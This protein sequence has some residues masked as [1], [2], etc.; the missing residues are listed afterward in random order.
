MEDV[1]KFYGYLVYYMVIWSIIWLFGLLYGYLVNFVPIW[2]ILYPFGIFIS[3]FGILYQEKSGNPVCW[4]KILKDKCSEQQE[5]FFRIGR[6]SVTR[7]STFF[8]DFLCSVGRNFVLLK[9][10]Q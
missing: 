1:S 5:S 4:H 8:G 6:A 10:A 2:C 9:I 7:I 3:R